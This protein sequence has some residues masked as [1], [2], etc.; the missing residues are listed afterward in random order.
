M[1]GPK[2]THFWFF[3]KILQLDKFDGADF[4]CVNSFFLDSSQRIHKKDIF[5]P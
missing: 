4:K 5:G 3:H 1:F 2:Y